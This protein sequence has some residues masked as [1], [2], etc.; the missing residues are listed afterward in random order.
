M[1]AND[2]VLVQGMRDTRATLAGWNRAPWP[3]L[4]GNSMVLALRGFACVAGFIAG[5]SLPLSAQRYSGVWRW[6]HE[7]AGPL[8]ISFVVGATTFSLG[9]QAWVLGSGASTLSAQ[10][11]IS[12]GLLVAALLPHAF[13]ELVALFLPL[14][15]WII[16]SRRGE[17]NQ[18]LAAT[19]VTVVPAVPVLVASSF[20]EV[21]VT[22]HILRT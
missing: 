21:Y 5:F 1:R 12:P 2:F 10:L 9:T 7:R 13:P 8:A 4:R 18:L 15:A 6:V 3:V 22:P 20:V 14:A 17:W 19:F 11:G 16:A